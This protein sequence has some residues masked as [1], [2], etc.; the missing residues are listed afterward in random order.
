LA[1]LDHPDAAALLEAA[2]ELGSRH[3]LSLSPSQATHWEV[4]RRHAPQS[5]GRSLTGR[6]D[7]ELA[8]SILAAAGAIAT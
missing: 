6:T 7:D 3:S 1:A 8:G 4:A 5:E 2:D